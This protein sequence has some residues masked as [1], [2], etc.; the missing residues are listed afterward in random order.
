VIPVFRV[1][2]KPARLSLTVSVDGRGGRRGLSRSCVRRLWGRSDGEGL[3]ERLGGS[4]E[5]LEN[6]VTLLSSGRDD[7]SEAG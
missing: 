2:P 5:D 6:I 7:G 4:L 1:T 3:H